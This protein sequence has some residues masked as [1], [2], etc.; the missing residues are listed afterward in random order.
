[1]KFAAVDRPTAPPPPRVKLVASVSRV[2][3][4]R[5]DRRRFRIVLPL[6]VNLAATVT[7]RVTRR[8][9]TVLRRT[10][11]VAAGERRLTMRVRARRGRYRLVVTVR[12][13]DGQVVLITRR[14]RLR[15]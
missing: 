6:R 5:T 8:A 11:R 10:W 14:L 4:R 1:M 15:R 9:R 13:T 2:H 12:T 3:A 7:A